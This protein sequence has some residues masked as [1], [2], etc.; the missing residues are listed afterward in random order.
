[1]TEAPARVP[2]VQRG[3][4][5]GVANLCAFVAV[6]TLN[7]GVASCIMFTMPLWTAALA[8]VF[9]GKRRLAAPGRANDRWLAG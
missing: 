9:A 6:S 1:M 7:L 2:M 8:Y 3:L 5:G 4:L